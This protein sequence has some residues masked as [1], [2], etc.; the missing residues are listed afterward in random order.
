MS[1]PKRIPKTFEGKDFFVGI[2][3]H[4][5]QWTVT[6]R[7]Q[8]LSLKTLSMDPSPEAVRGHLERHYPGGVYH[9]AY[10]GGFCG[11]WIQRRFRD[12]GLDCIVVNAADIPTAHKD[13]DRKADDC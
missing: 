1:K 13:K 2:D 8:G 3:I 7:H 4:K 6:I 10:E 9:L 5:K 12:L 11:F